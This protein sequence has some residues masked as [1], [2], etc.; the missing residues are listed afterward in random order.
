MTENRSMAAILPN[1]SQHF[2]VKCFFTNKGSIF[3]KKNENGTKIDKKNYIYL[4]LYLI[5]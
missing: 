3:A 1:H 4:L 2:D 5:K